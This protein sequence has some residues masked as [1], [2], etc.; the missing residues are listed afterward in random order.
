MKHSKRESTTRGHKGFS[1]GT[2]DNLFVC[3]RLGPIIIEDILARATRIS[4]SDPNMIEMRI[5][6]LNLGSNGSSSR[7]TTQPQS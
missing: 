4:K 7:W 2:K 5:E 6:P 3:H 1:K